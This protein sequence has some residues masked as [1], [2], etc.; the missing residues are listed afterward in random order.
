MAQGCTCRGIG[1]RKWAA[2]VVGTDPEQDNTRLADMDSVALMENSLKGH[3]KKLKSA[4]FGAVNPRSHQMISIIGKQR[5][6][7]TNKHKQT[8]ST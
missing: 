6:K 8:K 5:N 7:Q 4:I 1:D 3:W 2:Q